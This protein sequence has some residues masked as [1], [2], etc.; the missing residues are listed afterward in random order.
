MKRGKIKRSDFESWLYDL[1][2]TYFKNLDPITRDYY[3]DIAQKFVVDLYNLEGFILSKNIVAVLR[4]V[5][6]CYKF[7]NTINSLI[8][9]ED[10]QDKIDA[11]KYINDTCYG[12][13]KGLL[14]KIIKFNNHKHIK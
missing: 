9:Q 7:V 5:G 8:E 11:L 2:N 1:Y 14:L 6:Q 3:K 13:L 10:S 4:F 12:F